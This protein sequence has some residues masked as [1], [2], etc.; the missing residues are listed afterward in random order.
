MLNP[1]DIESITILKDASATA[2]YGVRA[3]NGVILIETKKPRSGG[4][5]TVEYDSYIAAAAPARKL[6]VLT[7][8]QFRTFVQGQVV[9][10]RRDSTD[11]AGRA[12]CASGYADSAGL[13]GG[14]APRPPSAQGT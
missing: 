3:A 11:C 14:P 7:G 2:I 6:D 9:D 4:G 10:W 8:D 12:A 5:P 13:I 1:S